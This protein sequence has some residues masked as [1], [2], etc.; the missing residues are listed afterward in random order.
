MLSAD[1]RKD[2][3]KD[4]L[5]RANAAIF[6]DYW[7]DNQLGDD[8]IVQPSLFGNV[9][10]MN[11]CILRGSNSH[12]FVPGLQPWPLVSNAIQHAIEGCSLAD[13]VTMVW[14]AVPA[15]NIYIRY[16]IPHA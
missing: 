8:S 15:G 14:T 11:C 3:G 1:L 10:W 13:C 4:V 12:T 9:T 7:P 6:E 2:G 5:K 16:W